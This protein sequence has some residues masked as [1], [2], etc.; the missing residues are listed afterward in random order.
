MAGTRQ[1]ELLKLLLQN[2]SGLT[3]DEFA[4]QLS[5]TR[6]AVRQH[7][8]VLEGSELVQKGGTRPTGG[9]PEQLYVLTDKGNELFPRHYAWFA[10][11]LFEMVQAEVGPKG[12]AERLDALGSKVAASLVGKECGLEP[13]TLEEKVRHLGSIMEELGYNARASTS[14]KGIPII[15]ANNCVFHELARKHPTV[16][17]FDLSLLSAVTGASVE[18]AECMAKGASLCRF[19]FYS[20]D[21]DPEKPA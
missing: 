3:V 20:Q 9:R 19:R 7:L 10:Q 21:H 6:N 15:E 18:H 2:K 11:L 4:Q 13:A 5:V 8:E 1:R 17:R 14:L 16:C 12:M